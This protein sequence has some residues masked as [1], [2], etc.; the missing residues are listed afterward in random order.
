MRDGEGWGRSPNPLRHLVSLLL[1]QPVHR[2]HAFAFGGVE[3]NHAPGLAALDADL[4]DVAA[5]ELAAVGDQHELVGFL[6]RE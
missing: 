4:G 1:A 5:N 3:Y 2:H 6:D